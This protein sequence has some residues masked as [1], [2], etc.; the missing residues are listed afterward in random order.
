MVTLR[1]RRGYVFRSIIIIIF[2]L[3][4][5]FSNRWLVRLC[6]MNRDLLNT[7][8]DTKDCSGGLFCGLVKTI[9]FTNT[10]KREMAG[11]LELRMILKMWQEK[12]HLEWLLRYSI[13]RQSL[14]G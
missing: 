6:M 1:M 8:K 14:V 9:L 3:I 2:M 11:C 4:K 10:M 13:A 7:I 12:L 5:E